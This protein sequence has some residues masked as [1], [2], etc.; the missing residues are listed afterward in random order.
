MTKRMQLNNASIF[1]KYKLLIGIGI[2][3]VAVFSGHAALEYTS[4][5]HFCDVC[6]V[7]PHATELWKK[8][9]HYKNKTGVIVHCVACHLPPGGMEYYVEK[10]RFGV[11]DVYGTLFKDI[12]KINWEAKRKLEHARSFTSD[13]ACTNCHAELFS[14]NLSKK[15]ENAHVYYFHKKDRVRCINC[16][17]TVGHYREKVP[18]AVEMLATEIPA[19]KAAKLPLKPIPTDTFTNYTDFIPGT[20]VTFEMVAI[21][22]GTFLMGSPV[23]ESYRRSDEGPRR[24]VKIS[25][26]WMGK[27]EVTW[28]EWEIFYTQTA[29]RGKQEYASLVSELD[30]IT[31]P[32]PPYGTPDQGWGKGSRPAITMTHHAAIKYCEWLSSITGRNYR[33]PTEAEW[34]YACRGGTNSPY[35]FDGDPSKFTRKSWTNRLFGVDTSGINQYVWYEGNSEAQ[36]HPAYSRKPNPFGL[37][38]MPGNVKEFCLDWYDP[39]AYQQYP[40]DSLIIN[41]KGPKLGT[42]HVIRGGSFKS[43]AAELRSATRDRTRHDAWQL[44]DPQSPKSIWWYSDCN[45]VGFRIV[46]QFEGNTTSPDK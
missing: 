1:K 19:E 13:A 27:A 29:T 28:D 16:H 35:Y 15:G 46:R 40:S 20:N 2:G 39:H 12:S 21:P 14:L 26:F 11:R 38:N 23:S 30:V 8:S 6:H 43:D 17:L 41:P 25:P 3:I 9:P 42:E 4:A 31:G 5:D 7:H 36:T 37:S 32:T 44:T 10:V 18:E 45:D 24:K 33:L 34:E 22:G